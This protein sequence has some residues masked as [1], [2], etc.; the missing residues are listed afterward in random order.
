MKQS[1][2]EN[3]LLDIYT[4]NNRPIDAMKASFNLDLELAA[5]KGVITNLGKATTIDSILNLKIK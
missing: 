1:E 5:E 3:K 2:I 4:D